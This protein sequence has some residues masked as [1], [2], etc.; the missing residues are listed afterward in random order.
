MVTSFVSEYIRV[1]NGYGT[2]N[3]C[4]ELRPSTAM[5]L[6]KRPAFVPPTDAPYSCWVNQSPDLI[7]IAYLA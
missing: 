1:L 6:L 7:V 4:E 2:F 5:S 3:I